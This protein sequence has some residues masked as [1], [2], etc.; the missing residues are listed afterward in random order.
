MLTGRGCNNLPPHARTTPHRMHAHLPRRRRSLIP[1]AG[2]ARGI[3]FQYTRA[4]KARLIHTA[5]LAMSAVY[6]ID[7]MTKRSFQTVSWRS[8]PT[9]RVL[10]SPVQD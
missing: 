4:L 1:A 3:L 9:S 5:S 8:S 6:S 7:Y 10:Q 2:N